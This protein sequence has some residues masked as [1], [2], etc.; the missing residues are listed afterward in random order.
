[1][2]YEARGELPQ[3]RELA[4]QLLGLAQREQHPARLMR[5][6][7]VLGATS[8]YLGAFAPARAYL[9][10]GIALDALPRD[11]S[12]AVRLSDQIQGGSVLAVSCRRHVA[13]TLWYLGY[14]EQALQRSHEAITLAQDGRIPI[15]WP[16]R[17]YF[18]TQSC[19][20]CAAR[21]Q[22]RKRRPRRSSS[23]RANRSFQLR[24]YGEPCCGA[25]PW[26]R[27]GKSTEGIAQMRQGMDAH[28]SM[29]AM[30]RPYR[31]GLA[32]PGLWH[33]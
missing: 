26:R 27:R 9:D 25:G 4:E 33:G 28:R 6:Y 19:T 10:Q 23:W 5:A 12:A 32:G 13:L 18:A 3:A 29:G 22:R 24:R 17:C 16:M 20:V 15:A 30:Q 2:I 7:N 14:P 1:M 21:H 31:S 8:L 11:R